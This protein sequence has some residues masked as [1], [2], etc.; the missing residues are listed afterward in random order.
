LASATITN[1]VE[2]LCKI[3][4]HLVKMQISRLVLAPLIFFPTRIGDDR[5]AD[6]AVLLTKAIQLIG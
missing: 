6:F 3:V 5:A 1:V 4:T 2:R